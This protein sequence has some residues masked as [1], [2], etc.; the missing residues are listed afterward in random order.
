MSEAH[1]KHLTREELKEK[2]LEWFKPAHANYL[3]EENAA[4]YNTSG[5][6]EDGG[7]GSGSV[8]PS[9]LLAMIPLLLIFFNN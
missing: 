6:D 9:I 5:D 8:A 1:K 2:A 3:I 4:P 7:G